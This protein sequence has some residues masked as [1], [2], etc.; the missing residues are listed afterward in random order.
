MAMVKYYPYLLPGRF[1]PIKTTINKF[2]NDDHFYY[3][4]LM[5][6]GTVSC[7]LLYKH[8]AHV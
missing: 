7:Q 3:I 6:T 5:T 8:V 2:I 1:N 4:I